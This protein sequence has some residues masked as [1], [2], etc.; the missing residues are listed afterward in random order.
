MIQVPWDQNHS[1]VQDDA[2]R[3]GSHNRDIHSQCV[4]FNNDAGRTSLG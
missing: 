2:H 4:S 3:T 1:F